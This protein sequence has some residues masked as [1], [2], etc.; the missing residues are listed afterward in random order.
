VPAYLRSRRHDGSIAWLPGLI[1][2]GVAGASI[3][4]LLLAAGQPLLASALHLQGSPDVRS[5]VLLL[6]ICFPPI[7][8][9]GVWADIC[10][11]R[12][13]NLWAM[14]IPGFSSLFMALILVG[15]YAFHRLDNLGL[16]LSMAL[17]FVIVGVYSLIRI[18][19]S[20]P[21]SM[22]QLAIWRDAEFRAFLRQL[23]ASSME[24]LA[25]TGNQLLIIY[26]LAQSG[27]GFI[28]GNTCAMRIAMLGYTL[29]GM[30]LG[31][32]AQARLATTQEA[33]LPLVFR[34]WITRVG[35]LLV[36]FAALIIVLRVPIIR[37]VYM[38]GKFQGSDLGIVASL[39][40]PWAAYIVVMNLNAVAARYLF[41][42]SRG[43]TYVR[44]QLAAYVGENLLR[45]AI[46]GHMH[47]AWVIWVSV[48][49]EGCSLLFSLRAC[50][51]Y[52]PHRADPAAELEV[53]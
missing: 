53:A 18:V 2:W 14:S 9:I 29:L 45:F 49:V 6:S 26:F 17:G 4:T 3:L 47:A 11:A 7:V 38:H 15:L 44:L 39:L 32:L 24:N 35:A 40:P 52:S 30:P 31:Q 23:G 27:T 28:S 10:T 21:W 33:D 50:S 19:Y 12:G 5:T 13:H 1:V 43:T 25:Y 46:A 36:C 16:P 34:R 41:I 51:L 42:L 8:V 22:G 20:Q 48:A 37:I